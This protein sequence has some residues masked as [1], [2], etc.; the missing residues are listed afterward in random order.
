MM[1]KQYKNEDL[2]TVVRYEEND[3]QNGGKKK[4]DEVINGSMAP[5]LAEMKEHGKSMS[6]MKTNQELQK[7]GLVPDPIQEKPR[8]K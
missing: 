4:I 1:P 5:D 6:N 2:E 8:E 7:S 3:E